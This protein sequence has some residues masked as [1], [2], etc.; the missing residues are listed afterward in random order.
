MKKGQLKRTLERQ[1]EEES[2]KD[3]MSRKTYFADQSGLL[4][5]IRLMLGLG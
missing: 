1:A 5:M 4:V 2:M 3:G